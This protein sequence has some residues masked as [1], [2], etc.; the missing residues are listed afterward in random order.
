[1][2]HLAAYLPLA[3][4]LLLTGCGGGGGGSDAPSD[5]ESSATAVE[6]AGVKGPLA[7]AEVRAYALDAS[8]AGGKGTRLD[9]G[10]T[11]ESTAI[12]GL[13]LDDDTTG[14]V[15][16]EVTAD[17][18]TVDISTGTTPVITKL[19]SI[20][21]AERLLAGNPAFPT[22]LTTMAARLALKNAD[23]NTF[24]Y[25]G[26]NDGTPTNAEV[27]RALPVAAAQVWDTFD[28]DLAQDLG[29]D[30]NL[31]VTAPLVTDETDTTQEIKEVLAYRTAV[32]AVAAVAER[33]KDDALAANASTTVTTEQLFQALTDDLSD[34]RIDGQDD[35]TP[36]T[37]FDDNSNVAT[38]VTADVSG[39]T[40]PGTS[41]GL[42]SLNQALQDETGTTGS[43]A[44]TT[45]L[46][47]TT[48]SPSTAKAA[49]DLDGDGTP[50]IDDSDIDGDGVANSTEVSDGTL[51]AIPDTDD[52][53]LNDGEE[54]IQGADPLA[55]DSDGDGIED[56][57]E[58]NN[59]GTEPT[60]ADTD[61]DGIFDG[62]EVADGTDPVV[63]DSDGDG[64]SDGEEK[65]QGTQPLVSDTD[66]DALSDGDEV[67]TH[68]TDPLV[69]DSDGDNVVDGQEVTDGTDPLV[70]DTDGDGLS[71]GDENAEGTDP[72][73]TDTDGDGLTDAEEVNSGTDPQDPDSDGDGVQDGRD[74]F[75]QDATRD[76]DN[77]GDGFA[78]QANGDADPDDQD[79]CNPDD[80]V[81]AC[82]GISEA[83]VWNEFNWNQANWQ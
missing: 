67:N 1:M 10:T 40:V 20:V 51:P 36:I 35:S 15:V 63:A 28:F 25:V 82:T 30:L 64:L 37:T 83:A 17:D 27:D 21:D 49:P 50:D 42:D 2:R 3:A 26:N 70:P 56:G 74:A 38:S 9:T 18:D 41:T 79:P 23:K 57:E 14:L 11:D 65:L 4:A 7:S 24:G 13:T 69:V 77:D 39:L 54:K 59:L 12:Q 78:P 62:Q 16:I 71:D 72:L 58:V 33:L 29:V 61:A 46:D 68:G 22:T 5:P 44:D 81:D 45:E 75:P 76:T 80:T 8:A 31:F 60:L 48:A 47:T 43:S 19:V 55:A 32:E 34:G 73:V 6:G 52:D 53:G 66:G